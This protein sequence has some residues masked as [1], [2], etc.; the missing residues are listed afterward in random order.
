MFESLEPVYYGNI[1]E[2]LN[3]ISPQES[4]IINNITTIIKIVPQTK[5]LFLWQDKLKPDFDLV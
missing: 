4:V 2:K 3:T 5:C 1:V